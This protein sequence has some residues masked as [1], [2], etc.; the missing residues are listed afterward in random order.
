VGRYVLLLILAY[1]R[2]ARFAGRIPKS[3]R[4]RIPPDYEYH[5]RVYSL[6]NY[7][8]MI[9][10]TPRFGAYAEAIAA[11]VRPGDTVAEI[12]CGPGVFSM[13]ACRAGARRVY[14]I[15]SQDIIAFARTLAAANSLSNQIEFLQSESKR[16]ELPE[17]VNVVVS[18]IRGALPLFR[19]AIPSLE[20]A[21][22][23]FLAPGGIMIP[24]RDTL[25]AA[26]MEAEAYH[27]RM[28]SPWREPIAG[29]DLSLAIL[30][31]LNQIHDPYFEKSQ[32]L[33]G[34]EDWGVLDYTT[35][36]A[37]DVSAEV[38]FCAEREGTGHGV[39][40]WF[41][42]K[43]FEGIGYSAG[44][45]TSTVHGQRFL[46]WLEP[47]ALKEGEGIQVA[48]K[49]N[50]VGRDYVWQWE[51]KIPAS[52]RRGQIHFRQSTFQG[53]NYSLQDIRRTA[54]D[55]VPVLSE[56]SKADLWMMERM[57]GSASLQEIAK[58]TAERFPRVF[59]SWQEAFRRVA[60][61]SSEFSR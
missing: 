42:T 59:P 25:K 34:T 26:V 9:A 40:V 2:T 12:G 10:D 21:R 4:V 46:P 38:N 23:R 27:A 14:A 39:C 3:T 22:K 56:A 17:R 28:A 20:D 61:L 51:T 50:L 53:A 11:A 54:A 31:L 52:S 36:A 32:L 7:G 13:L 58:S 30:P 45:G 49:A 5:F 33:T 48:I 47:V 35:G 55:Y 43:L 16:V 60:D 18:D 29:L 19:D 44:P 57:N 37:A 41:E 1:H 8:D 15:E 24:E 6:R